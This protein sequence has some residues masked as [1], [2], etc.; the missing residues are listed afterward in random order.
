[1]FVSIVYVNHLLH[2]SMNPSTFLN[3][4]LPATVPAFRR[5]QPV[6]SW[7]LIP[8][9]GK[10]LC[11]PKRH[12]KHSAAPRCPCS[13]YPSIFKVSVE[14]PHVATT[15]LAIVQYQQLREDMQQ[16]LSHI[17]LEPPSVSA[18]ASAIIK[19]VIQYFAAARNRLQLSEHDLQCAQVVL[20]EWLSAA[21]HAAPQ[22]PYNLPTHSRWEQAEYLG[23][24]ISL[25]ST[26]V[27]GAADKAANTF[28]LMCPLLYHSSLLARAAGPE[29]SPSPLPSPAAAAASINNFLQQNPWQIPPP[30]LRYEELP[31]LYGQWKQHKSKFRWLSAAGAVALTPLG[32]MLHSVLALALAE[33]QGAAARQTAICRSFLGSA[34]Q[35]FPIIS[36]YLEVVL[37][38]PEQHT[39]V[40]QL[41]SGDI[42]RCYEAV[43]I[44]PAD[45]DSLPARL[46]WILRQL[47]K[48]YKEQHQGKQPAFKVKFPQEQGMGPTSSVQFTHRKVAGAIDISI[49]QLVEMVTYLISNA[50]ATAAGKVIL[51][52]YGIPQGFNPCPDLINLYLLSYEWEWLL[53]LRTD[54]TQHQYLAAYSQWYRQ[55]D[56]LLAIDNPHLEQA[57]QDGKVYPSCLSIEATRSSPI[58]TTF[59]DLELLISSNRLDFSHY[60]KPFDFFTTRYISHQANRPVHSMRSVFLGQL[61]TAVYHSSSSRRFKNRVQHIVQQLVAKG[62]SGPQLRGWAK[63]YLQHQQFPGARFA[64]PS[65]VSWL[66]TA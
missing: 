15:D 35:F 56:D 14:V 24:C 63:H 41:Y 6:I 37:N 42:T 12:S 43:P 44:D 34:P 62:A 52:R 13:S 65:Q 60:Q 27:V 2:R 4:I 10:Q 64:V 40:S 26:F 11:N 25:T 49:P 66:A 58:K 5:I 61:L 55:I 19:G 33:L 36:S 59:L 9:M 18:A 17:P 50:Y 29:F 21:V 54:P 45:P 51:Q 46:L 47:E 28:H 39:P 22:L 32:Q 3:E 1:M 23:A 38:L 16:G 31:I 7:S 30:A 48:D 53:R 57:L 8:N 20:G